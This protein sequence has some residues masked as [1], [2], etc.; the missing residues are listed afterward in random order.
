M[1]WGF[2]EFFIIFDGE[3]SSSGKKDNSGMSPGGLGL[4][5]SHQIIKAHSGNIWAQSEG[6]GKG[7]T[8][9]IELPEA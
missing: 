4:Y 7:S 1:K 2:N 3:V 5:V 9:F 8:F 6:V